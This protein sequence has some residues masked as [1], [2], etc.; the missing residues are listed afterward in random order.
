MRANREAAELGVD[1]TA[2][3]GQLAIRETLEQGFR[4]RGNGQKVDLAGKKVNEVAGFRGG[5]PLYIYTDRQLR[6]SDLRGDGV[7]RR[8]LGRRAKEVLVFYILLP[9]SNVAE[10]CACYELSKHFKALQNLPLFNF[11]GHPTPS[12]IQGSGPISK[13]SWPTNAETRDV[14]FGHDRKSE[15]NS[16]ISQSL[17]TLQCFSY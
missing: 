13:D 9:Y 10:Q 1:P 6:P 14:F 17:A 12:M 5:F 4:V 16:S 7:G 2:P 11:V 3:R 15:S 8:S